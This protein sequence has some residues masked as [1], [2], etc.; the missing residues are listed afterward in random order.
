MRIALSLLALVVAAQAFTQDICSNLQVQVFQHPIETN[1]LVVR[2]ENPDSEPIN[3]P[4]WKIKQGETV[5][6]EGETFFFQLPEVSHHIME[7]LI[8][9]EEMQSYTFELELYESFGS[10]LVCTV[11]FTGVVYDPSFCIEGLLTFYPV[12]NINQEVEIKMVDAFNTVLVNENIFFNNQ[13][14]PVSIELCL[15]RACYQLSVEAVGSTLQANGLLS[16]ISSDIA[17]YS[18]VA[19]SGENLSVF[20]LDF[21][22]GCAFV[23]VERLEANEQP[24]FPTF[25]RKGEVLAP[26]E[27]FA[28]MVTLELFDVQG[29]RCALQQGYAI[30]MPDQAGIFILHFSTIH[31][32]RGRQKVVVKG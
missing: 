28:E 23:N 8:S 4:S 12:A 29:K 25:A 24:R 19:N 26:F 5:V 21:Y 30:K 27:A 13:T 6:A 22:E 10:T 15:D 2:C 9:I 14:L 1:L 7:A 17:W 16:F 32:V 11:P 18:V 20:E 3:Y 31:G